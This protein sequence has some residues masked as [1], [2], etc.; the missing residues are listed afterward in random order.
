MLSGDGEGCG[1]ALRAGRHPGRQSVIYFRIFRQSKSRN[2]FGFSPESVIPGDPD[3]AERCHARESRAVLAS[4]YC[5]IAD[6]DSRKTAQSLTAREDWLAAPRMVRKLRG[7]QT[8]RSHDSPLTKI[9]II[10]I[11]YVKCKNSRMSGR[12]TAYR[13]DRRKRASRRRHFHSGAYSKIRYAPLHS[14]KQPSDRTY[15][16]VRLVPILLKNSE[17]EK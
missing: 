2:A 3:S 4:V 6:R 11:L 9:R 1:F 17:N 12:S 7:S 10:Q 15:R 13:S 16:H 5:E 14:E 8:A